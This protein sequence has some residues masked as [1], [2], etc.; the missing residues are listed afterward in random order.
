MRPCE[1]KQARWRFRNWVACLLEPAASGRVVWHWMGFLYV[2][3][4]LLALG[5][6]LWGLD[7]ETDEG[8]I[9]VLGAAA[10]I[11]GVVI[12]LFAR[13]IPAGLIAVA[14]LAGLGL[15]SAGIAASHEPDSPFLFFY[16]WVGV[17]AWFFL[18]TRGAMAITLVTIVVTA[19][20][21]AVVSRADPDPDAG[22][23]WLMTVGSLIAV[24]TLAGVLHG[25]AQRLVAHDE[26]TGLLNRRGYHQRLNEEIA[27]ARRY[28]IP[29]SIVLGDLDDFKALNDRFGH[30]EGDKALRDFAGM[31]CQQL[32]DQTDFI[33]RVGGEEFAV[34]LPNTGESGAI[35]AAERLRQSV[36]EHLRAPDG[37]PVTASFGVATFPQHGD[38][39]EILL[40]HADQAMYG[41]KALGRN[42]TVAFAE[43]LPRANEPT[44]EHEHIQAVVVL[45]ETLDLRDAGTRAHSEVVASL[46]QRI[47][48]LSDCRAGAS[49]ESGSPACSTTSARSECPTM[50]S[51][52]P[53]RLMRPSGPRC[54]STLN[55]ARGSL[56][57]P[58]CTTSP[59]GARTP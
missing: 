37:T 59:S 24:S 19:A 5:S 2:A 41:A 11:L 22:A 57:P 33:S 28:G 32:R 25:R 50:S 46:A 40:D 8:V 31:C 44:R 39:A 10:T 58:A 43:S 45:A 23:W 51:A 56:K 6:V 15:I 27:R 49:N 34:M 53:D 20:V 9:A 14:L 29:L 16:F 52:S 7:P 17:E 13:H 36:S 12:S 47:A 55:S 3:A 48:A 4:G 38:A 1:C 26:L 21:I 18:R 30:R 35:L 42:R 54:K